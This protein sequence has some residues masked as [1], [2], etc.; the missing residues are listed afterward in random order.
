MQR[1]AALE[2]KPIYDIIVLD[3]FVDDAVPIHLITKEAFGIY[4]T[5][6]EK[7]NGILAVNISNRY[8]NLEPAIRKLGEAYGMDTIVVHSTDDYNNINSASWVLLSYDKTFTKHPDVLA[9]N[10]ASK[11][12]LGKTQLWTDDYSNLFQALYLD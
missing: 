5:L 12:D 6:L 8:L 7:K 11:I 10:D 1:Q 9:A 3:A 2:S 4:L